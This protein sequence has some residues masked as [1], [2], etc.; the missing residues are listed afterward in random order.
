MWCES[1]ARRRTTCRRRSSWCARASPTCRCSSSTSGTSPATSGA[2]AP[3]PAVV[4]AARHLVQ[5]G[6]A[7]FQVLLH[8]FGLLHARAGRCLAYFL[9]AALD[10]AAHQLLGHLDVALHA[11]VLAD[12][13]G[14]VRA[15]RALHQPRA[16]RRNAEGLAVPME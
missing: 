8:L 2:E 13:E 1:P 4:K 6:E 16:S 10:P 12:G 5:R 9:R 15:V 7:R 11:E 3:R 14:L